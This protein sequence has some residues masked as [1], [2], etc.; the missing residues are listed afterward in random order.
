MIDEALGPLLVGEDPTRIEALLDR[1]QR[2]LMI[3]GRRGLGM[4]ALS[5]DRPRAVGPRRQGASACRCGAARR[6]RAAARARVREP[7]ALRHASDVG[8]RGRRDRRAAATR[9]SSSTRPTSSRS[10]SRARPSATTSSSCSTRTARGRWSRRSRWRAASSRSAA[11]A[12]GAGVAAGG[13]S[14]AR[15]RARGE[16]RSP[17]ASGENE[18]TAFGF[19]RVRS[20]RAAWT[21]RSRA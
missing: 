13:L 15:A 17:I 6:P 16:R 4:F 14:R 18:A 21:S 9:R 12:R 11:L 8:P 1:L 19:A 3:W 10:R 5:G 20:R 2:A 7:P